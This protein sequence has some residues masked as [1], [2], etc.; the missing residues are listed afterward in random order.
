MI[1][2]QSPTISIA[3]AAQ[4]MLEEL[5]ASRLHVVKI[6]TDRGFV[7]VPVSSNAE[8]YRS[9]CRQ[10]K[11]ARRNKRYK[12]PRTIIK[13]CDTITHLMKIMRCDQRRLGLYHERLLQ[14]IEDYSKQILERYGVKV[15]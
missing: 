6:R 8:W 11:S 10:Y 15:A 3:E 4:L 5:T 9:F 7:R 2:Y 12:K 1:G 14:A 13:R